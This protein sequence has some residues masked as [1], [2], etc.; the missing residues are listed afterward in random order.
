MFFVTLATS[1]A[2]S[3]ERLASISTYLGTAAS[4]PVTW[5]LNAT[6]FSYGPFRA[7]ADF[8]DQ[9]AVAHHAGSLPAP[10]SDVR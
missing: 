9:V 8:S 3:W 10:T 7:L 2:T 1:A 5:A 6:V 4:H